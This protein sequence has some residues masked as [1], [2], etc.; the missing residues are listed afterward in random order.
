LSVEE[1]VFSV[2]ALSVAEADVEFF[3]VAFCVLADNTIEPTRN[4]RTGKIISPY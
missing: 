2:V 4:G 3:S 1:L